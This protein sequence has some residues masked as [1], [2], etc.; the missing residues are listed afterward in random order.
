MDK[1]MSFLIPSHFAGELKKG[2]ADAAEKKKQNASG[3]QFSRGGKA[4]AVTR[5]GWYACLKVKACAHT[6]CAEKQPKAA[7]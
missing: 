7:R 6:R 1:A 5:T 3:R 2:A 4:A